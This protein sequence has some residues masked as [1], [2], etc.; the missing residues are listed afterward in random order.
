MLFH[1]S[2]RVIRQ[3]YIKS[4]NGLLS[5]KQY[6]ASLT[7][8]KYSGFGYFVSICAL[9]HSALKV[10]MKI[11]VIWRLFWLKR[12]KFECFA[13]SLYINQQMRKFFCLMS[14]GF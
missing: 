14:F 6:I 8:V 12:T 4:G 3:V 2:H 11:V 7:F 1:P 13:L 10:I 9:D 5:G